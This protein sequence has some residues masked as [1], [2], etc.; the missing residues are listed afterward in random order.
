MHVLWA[1]LAGL[2]VGAVARALLRGRQY[3]PLWLTLLLGICGCLIGDGIAQAIGVGSTRGIDW[4]RHLLQVLSAM[5]LIGLIEPLWA[6][7]SR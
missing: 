2:I 5:L 1:L 6:K 3:I 4:T 7:R